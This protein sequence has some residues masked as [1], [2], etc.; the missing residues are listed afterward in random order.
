MKVIRRALVAT[1]TVMAMAVGAGGFGA[2][3]AAQTQ[4]HTQSQSQSEEM[5]RLGVVGQFSSAM[6]DWQGNPGFHLEHLF[7]GGGAASL[8]VPLRPRLSIDVRAGLTQKGVNGD[9]TTAAGNPLEG[10]VAVTYLTVPVFVKWQKTRGVRP[11]L[12][13]GPEFGVRVHSRYTRALGSAETSGALDDEIR[14]M[15]FGIAYG[16]GVPLA[17]GRAFAEILYS[18]GLRNVGRIAPTL[19]G[20]DSGHESLKTRTLTLGFGVRF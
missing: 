20:D 16:G 2:V 5:P 17:N 6:V 11:Y 14:R 9:L 3:A 1:M 13:V 12:M 19:S 10:H 15:D 4:S 8:D 7:R 18:H